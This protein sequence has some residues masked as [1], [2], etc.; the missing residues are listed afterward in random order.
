MWGVM[1]MVMA[2]GVR[3]RWDGGKGYGDGGDDSI[4]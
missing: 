1:M 2:Y 3:G 4:M